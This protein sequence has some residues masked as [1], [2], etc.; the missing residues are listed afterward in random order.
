MNKP[1]TPVINSK[2]QEITDETIS[3]LKILL[4]TDGWHRI[5]WRCDTIAKTGKMENE[6]NTNAKMVLA[7]AP[8]SN[9]QLGQK[10]PEATTKAQGLL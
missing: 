4:I 5:T 8:T 10:T 7:C 9:T 2:T 3:R 1:M 6:C